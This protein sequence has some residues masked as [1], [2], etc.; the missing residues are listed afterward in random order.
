[1]PEFTGHKDLRAYLRM[2]WRWKLLILVIVVAAPAIAY[3]MERGKPRIYQSSATIAVNTATVSTGG[4]TLVSNNIQAIAAL[5]NTT[6]VADIAGGSMKPAVPGD[7]IAGDVSA[8]AD[9]QTGFITITATADSPAFAAKVANAFATA[10]GTNQHNQITDAINAEVAALSGEQKGLAKDSGV[11]QTLQQQIQQTR[12]QLKTASEGAQ[13]IQAAGPEDTP[14]GPHPRRAVELGF[15]IGVLVAFA[16]V[17]LL[18]SADRRMRSP[19]DLELLTDLPLLA[20][21][22][23]SAFAGEL[24]TTPVDA[25]SFQTLRTSLTYFTVDKKIRS[26]LITSPGEQEGK[27]TVAVRLALASASAGLDVVLVDADLRR[28]GATTKLGLKPRHGL[29]LVLAEQRPVESAML[30]WPLRPEDTGRLRVLAAGPPPPNPAALVSSEE[31][32]SLIRTL[33]D[34]ADLVVIDTP[35]ALAV[36]DAVPM[37]QNVSGIVLVARMN[38]SS[39]DTIRRL[40]KIIVAAHGN[41]LGAVATGVTSGPGYEKYSQSYYAPEGPSR[42]GRRRGKASGADDG[43][44]RSQPSAPNEPSDNGSSA[45]KIGTETG[46]ASHNA[47]E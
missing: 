12:A 15:V 45:L 18:E 37:M 9:L 20:A 25:E 46:S 39:R 11:Y 14:V 31:M 30:E 10:L 35:A 1:M 44:A 3:F 22:A 4:S 38:R 27:S 21:I 33:E 29:G 34:Q 6:T 47:P 7:S 41:L 42:K 32:R 40:Q 13:T 19:D 8:S 43:I 26:V 16:L 24:D 28:A 17:V 23:P 2:V 5:V 36:S